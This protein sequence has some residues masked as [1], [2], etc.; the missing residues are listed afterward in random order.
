MFVVFGGDGEAERAVELERGRVVRVH[1]QRYLLRVV[2]LQRGGDELPDQRPPHALPA[3]HRGDDDAPE[4]GRAGCARQHLPEAGGIPISVEQG[5][6]VAAVRA[7]L[8]PGF[9][10]VRREGEHGSAPQAQLLGGRDPAQDG[11]QVL[12]RG[13]VEGVGHG[14]GNYSK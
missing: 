8:A 14:W 9:L 13:G 7:Y 3:Q 1:V 6:G 12:R 11:A 4:V 5:E 10:N 2:P